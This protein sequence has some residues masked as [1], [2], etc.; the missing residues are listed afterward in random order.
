MSCPAF[1]LLPVSNPAP[2]Q[3][4]IF[5]QCRV[6]GVVMVFSPPCRREY[7]GSRFISLAPLHFHFALQ[8][9]SV[10]LDAQWFY[11]LFLS[12]K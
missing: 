6:G 7:C 5:P 3:H 1:P 10:S 11:D 9:I 4:D 8:N 12:R 2:R